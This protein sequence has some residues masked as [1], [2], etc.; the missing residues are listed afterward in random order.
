MTTT[1]LSA[2]RRPTGSWR[3]FG[4]LLATETKVWLRDFAAVFFGILFPTVLMI[5]VGYAIPGMRD[6]ILD[7]PETSVWYGLTPIATYL[8]V[9]I[10]MALGT[11]ALTVLPVTFATF[12]EKGVLRRLGTT[13]MRSQGIVVAHLLI[14]VA[15]TLVG[16]LV[17][18]MV[19]RFMFDV[20]APGNIGVVLLAFLL[21]M[22]AMFSLGMLIAAWAPKA[23]T[24]NAVS[25][26]LYFP[27]LMLAG[28]WTPGPIMPELLQQIGQF[29][30]LGAAAQALTTGWFESGFPALQMVVMAVWTAVLLPVAI[31]MFRWS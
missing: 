25:M 21:G 28:L 15:T 11:A 1:T 8:P 23:S 4:T 19:G 22:A 3:G 6:P 31:R 16:V 7:A 30:P 13:P 9:V 10:A 26:L 14:N 29:T 2:T 18:V 24:A 27:M 12:R 20:P 5:G 17:A